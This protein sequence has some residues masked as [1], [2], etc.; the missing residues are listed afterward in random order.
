MRRYL[1]AV[2]LLASL[3]MHDQT[4]A[5]TNSLNVLTWSDYMDPEVVAEF[6][7]AFDTR[8]NFS[9]FESDSERDEK[10]AIRGGRGYD[11]I[12]VGGVQLSRY[13]RRQWL[14]PIT[15]ID[16]PNQA[17]IDPRW[18]DCYPEADGFGL[19]YFWG[20]MGIGYRSDLYAEGFSSW[21]QLLQPA[22]ELHGRLLMPDFT[23][24]AM[25][26]AMK[27]LGHS[28]NASDR[29]LIRTG[30]ELLLAQQPAVRF[31]RY[32]ALDENSV[33]VSGDVVAGMMY[34]GDVLM[35]REHAPGMRFVIPEE[36]GL[37]WID[38]LTVAQSSTRKRLAFD[39]L[40]FLN[41]PQIA[42][43]QARY[44]YYPSPNAAAAALLPTDFLANPDIYPS[45]DVLQRSEFIQ[46]LPPRSQKLIN[47]LGVQLRSQP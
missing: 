41:E 24:E 37:L 17:L 9:Y 34:G 38:Y 39:F 10:L 12:M 26:A 45:A 2:V 36:G 6:E 25:G 14:A 47:T 32:P 18:R 33:F 23:R 13:A 20:T 8:V 4:A 7:Q 35:L 3:L 40:N 5:A 44:V 30:S 22:P 31:Y 15:A 1:S 28:I 11:V 43:R 46:P 19:P 27:A 42:A 16:V 21:K 29:E